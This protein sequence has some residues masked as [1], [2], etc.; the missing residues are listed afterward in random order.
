[1]KEGDVLRLYLLAFSAVV[2]TVLPQRTCRPDQATCANGQ[3]IPR[4][5]VCDGTS[6]CYD[7]SDEKNCRSSQIC[8][9][10]EFQCENK[11]CI[12]KTWR[13][14]GDDDCLDGSDEVA[15]PTSP[16]GSACHFNEWQ[17]SSGTQ[18]IPR[19]FHCDGEVDCQDQSDEIGCSKY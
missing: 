5:K 17:C 7:S 6:D 19:S 14:D 3:C 1:M 9:P 18:C 2:P 10:N 11:R 15:C 4:D 8:E 12:L 13:C 16:P